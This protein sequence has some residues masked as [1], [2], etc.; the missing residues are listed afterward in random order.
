MKLPDDPLFA[1]VARG[2]IENY[3]E[4][5]YK[6]WF[7]KL[8]FVRQTS[9]LGDKILIVT[10]SE[11]KSDYIKQKYLDVL[12]NLIKYHDN[13]VVDC[14]VAVQLVLDDQI[15]HENYREFRG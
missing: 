9:N 14:E 10:D 5:H 7:E 8:G 1:K 11:F 4:G 2:F 3:D 12:T 6:S 13:S 15:I